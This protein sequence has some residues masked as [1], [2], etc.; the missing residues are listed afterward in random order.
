MQIDQLFGLPAH[1]LLVHLPVVLI[2]L[3][4]LLAILCVAWRR[5]RKVLSLVVALGATISMLGAQIAVMSGSALEER[6]KETDL[7]RQHAE[8][9]EATRNF[10]ILV[11][12]VAAA[13]FVREWGS[14][15]KVPG[16]ETVRRLLAP[17]TVGAVLSVAL[18]ASAGLTTV[19]VVRTGHVGAKATWQ[20]RLDASPGGPGGLTRDRDHD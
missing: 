18:V 17:R 12:L 20:D 16:A 4:L 6:V 10:A 15:V 5:G 11:F 13:L 2:P 8:L 9:G 19:W 3:T 7:V 14:H 1:P